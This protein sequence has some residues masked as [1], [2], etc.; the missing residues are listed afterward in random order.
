[1]ILQEGL[2]TFTGG[3]DQPNEYADLSNETYWTATTVDELNNLSKDEKKQITALAFDCT[4]DQDDNEFILER[5]SE[6]T[7]VLQIYIHM[8]APD[9]EEVEKGWDDKGSYVDPNFVYAYN[10]SFINYNIT[11]SSGEWTT[12]GVRMSDGTTVR[13]AEPE[14]DIYKKVED[15][16]ECRCNF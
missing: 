9:A 6:K 14:P 15:S 12:N 2:D 1:M 11:N 16:D 8:I 4:K 13:I 10:N 3:S 7:G 5:N